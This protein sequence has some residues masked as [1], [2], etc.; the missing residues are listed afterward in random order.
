MIQFAPWRT[1]LEDIYILNN[2]D[3]FPAC[4]N[5]YSIRG[6]SFYERGSYD[7]G[8]RCASTKRELPYD[9]NTDLERWL[10]LSP[11]QIV[12]LQAEIGKILPW[13]S[14][15]AT[16]GG[17]LLTFLVTAKA[18]FLVKLP[19]YWPLVQDPEKGVTP[20]YRQ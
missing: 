16:N 5:F 11:A 13:T 12:K 17:R 1:L 8:F 19:E 15:V 9:K 3:V 4:E 2:I 10:G 14:R 20:R 6:N 18:L 7:W